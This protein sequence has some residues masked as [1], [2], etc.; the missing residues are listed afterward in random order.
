LQQL[1]ITNEISLQHL[2][3]YR[4][5]Q[6]TLQAALTWIW[7]WWFC[8]VT[9]FLSWTE[10]SHKNDVRYLYRRI[11]GTNGFYWV[12]CSKRYGSHIKKEV[13]EL[14]SNNAVLAQN[15]TMFL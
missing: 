13:L 8:V 3:S 5:K 15:K 10:T 11:V 2:H 1:F 6:E 14:D 7:I 4:N 9:N 12:L